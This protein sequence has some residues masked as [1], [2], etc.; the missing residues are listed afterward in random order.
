M[1]NRGEKKRAQRRRILDTCARLFRKQ[2]FDGTTIDDILEPAGISRQTFFNYFPSK[3]AVLRELGFE[4]MGE[5]AR[6]A[7]ERGR[8]ARGGPLLVRL[9]SLL[10]RQLRAI[11]D[12][13][14][15]MRLV[16]TRSGMFFPQ[17]PEARPGDE[18]AR[19]DRTRV[20]FEVLAAGVR[21]GQERG[22]LRDDVDPYQVAEIY[23]AVFYV[24]TRL[25][26]TDT[27]GGRQRLD[28]RMLRALDILVNG[29][30]PR[31][32]SAGSGS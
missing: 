8:R 9:R 25:W 26:L 12:D 30:R 24:T 11:E 5:Q 31:E 19:Q 14:D 32:G 18:A 3:E 22:E 7:V 10:R 4:W 20:A 29:L 27:W 2:G 13:R 23:T 6:L 21:A 15:F 28:T 17:S 16:F 1:A